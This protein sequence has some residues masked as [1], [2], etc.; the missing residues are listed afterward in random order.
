MGTSAERPRATSTDRAI[1][2]AKR[3]PTSCVR[4]WTST[5]ARARSARPAGAAASSG[6]RPDIARLAATAPAAAGG[7]G[8][9]HPSVVRDLAGALE[10]RDAMLEM[11]T[12]RSDATPSRIF[13]PPP[14]M[15]GSRS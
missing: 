14:A 12:R 15:S 2:Y 5:E 4:V 3:S 8:E 9:L 11:E 10:E 1:S 6:S 13:L 7:E